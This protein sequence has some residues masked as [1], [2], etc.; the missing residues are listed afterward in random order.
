[1]AFKTAFLMAFSKNIAERHSNG[2][3]KASGNMNA[4][5][6]SSSKARTYIF[7]VFNISNNDIDLTCL[8]LSL[9]HKHPIP[10]PISSMHNDPSRHDIY[11]HYR[12]KISC[13]STSYKYRATLPFSNKINEIDD[14]ATICGIASFNCCYSYL[15][16]TSIAV[17]QVFPHISCISALS[18]LSNVH[19]TYQSMTENST[20]DAHRFL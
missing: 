20:Y 17:E 19:C 10:R 9:S 8:A 14:F 2:L 6:P 1:M 13:Q 7:Y 11:G 18:I 4:L 16:Q 5:N 3:P 15:H 12:V